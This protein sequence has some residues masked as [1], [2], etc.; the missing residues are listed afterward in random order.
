MGDL[1]SEIKADYLLQEILF[2]AGLFIV[3]CL[4]ASLWFVGQSIIEWIG[5]WRERRKNA[6]RQW[7]DGSMK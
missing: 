2:C 1:W 5:E 7:W 3:V 4:L 6:S